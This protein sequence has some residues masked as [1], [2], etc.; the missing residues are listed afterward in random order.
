MAGY[1]SLA[2]LER[3][4]E[5]DKRALMYRRFRGPTRTLTG[6]R[7]DIPIRR[8]LAKIEEQRKFDRA[9]AAKVGAEEREEERRQAALRESREYAEQQAETKATEEKTKATADLNARRALLGMPP[10]EPE[11]PPGE[12][13]PPYLQPSEGP[14]LEPELSGRPRLRFRREAGINPP[15][16]QLQL[17]AGEPPE[18]RPQLGLGPQVGTE[19]EQAEPG[20]QL[21]TDLRTAWLNDTKYTLSDAVADQAKRQADVS[22]ERKERFDEGEQ[23]RKDLSAL[24]DAGVN[25]QL[26]GLVEAGT[27]TAKDALTKQAGIEK[28]EEAGAKTVKTR[29]KELVKKQA[30]DVAKAT[31]VRNLKAIGLAKG[32]SKATAEQYAQVGKIAPAPKKFNFEEN[33]QMTALQSAYKEAVTYNE[34]KAKERIL[35]EMRALVKSAEARVTREREA[36]KE[37]ALDAFLAQ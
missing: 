20:L 21:D 30:A 3:L 2:A 35:N 33:N 6:K 28:S 22:K 5:H 14:I 36:K 8:D 16:G 25:R 15:P 18:A 31:K 13:V 1:A 32:A 7:P 34:T 9:Q 19:P 11:Q 4:N 27:L 26:I 17:E 12:Q 23:L 37:G 24:E 10:L 29:G